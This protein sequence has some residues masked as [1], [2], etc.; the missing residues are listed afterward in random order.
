M[1]R[2]L[3]SKC[4]LVQIYALSLNEERLG[5][6]SEND[7]I[8]IALAFCDPQGTYARH[9]AVTMASIFAN[10]PGRHICIHIIHDETLTVA[11]QTALNRLTE[12]YSQEIVYHN[13][14]KIY[15]QSPIFARNLNFQ[16]FRGMMFRLFIPN[17]ISVDK[18]IY[19]DCDIVVNLDIYDLWKVRIDNYAIAVVR[20]FWAIEH[21]DGKKISW[22]LLLFW[23]LLGITPESYF[24]SGVMLMNLIKLRSE[25]NITESMYKFFEY[26]KTCSTLPDQ[27]FLNWLFANDRL[28][29]DERFNHIAL[30]NVKDSLFGSIWHMAGGSAKPWNSYTRPY[31][32]DL[33]WKYLRLTP[34]CENDDD[35]LHL[36]LTGMASSPLM[37]HHSSSCVYRLFEQFKDNVFRAHI[38]TVLPILWKLLLQSLGFG[39]KPERKI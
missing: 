39:F 9:V 24:N 17:I 33:Y 19:L 34:Y 6:M 14:Y 36:V 3:A 32:D 7:V 29:L 15:K 26:Y 10:A 37:H 27:D 22:R 18:I 16:G 13:I 23:K 12:K 30:L 31:V 25:Y 11:N 2:A 35:L 20:D 5:K 1:L 21:M 4:I 28:L 38:W 8:H